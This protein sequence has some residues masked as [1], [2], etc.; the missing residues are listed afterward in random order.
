MSASWSA[1][2]AARII[3]S[4]VFGSSPIAQCGLPQREGRDGGGIRAQDAGAEADRG[5]LRHGAQALLF[6]LGKAA[7]WPDQDRPGAGGGGGEG[8]LGRGERFVGPEDAAIGGP[9]G[10]KFVEMGQ[11]SDFGDEGAAAL[12]GGLYRVGLQAVLPD[13]FGV[14]EGGLHGDDARGAEF[15]GFFDDEI[16]ARLFDRRKEQP[17]VRRQLQRA[18]LR[19]TR[20]GAAAFSGAGDGG[21]PFAIVAVEQK[22]CGANLQAHHAKEIMRLIGVQRN[23]LP[24][25]QGVLYKE[26]DL[27][28]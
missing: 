4:G 5:D 24:R 25:G 9:L 3:W 8:M 23:R 12:F 19:D 6:R 14:G 13:T 10:E 1:G 20:Q 17:E 21:A 26:P 22:K 28:D 18:G 16:G 2:V 15:G 7:L 11:V 27:C